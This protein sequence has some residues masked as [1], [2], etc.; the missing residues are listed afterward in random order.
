MYFEKLN[1]YFQKYKCLLKKFILKFSKYLC[2][3]NNS[4]FKFSKIYLYLRKFKLNFPIHT[5]NILF[6]C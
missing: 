2:I 3:P 6:F 4:N 1:L 5:F